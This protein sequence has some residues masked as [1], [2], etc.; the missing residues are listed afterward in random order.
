MSNILENNLE[1]EINIKR[2]EVLFTDWVK[3]TFKDI[4]K[5]DGSELNILHSTSNRWMQVKD[6]N[7]R[8]IDYPTIIIKR[9]PDIKP[10]EKLFLYKSF[11]NSY[12]LYRKI[13]KEQSNKVGSTVLDIALIKPPTYINIY[14]DVI[15]FDIFITNA[16][17]FQQLLLG[18][19]QKTVGSVKDK[20]LFFDIFYENSL[21][22]SNIL[23]QGVDNK[24]IIVGASFRLEGFFINKND[25]KIIQ[26][27]GRTRIDVKETSFK[28]Q[29]IDS[30]LGQIAVIETT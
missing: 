18:D 15:L 4:K 30:I 17:I 24:K 19:L 14:Y 20:L 28:G 9:K 13:N 26:S 6:Q 11:N 21:D 8:N 23:D 2:L 22:E 16:N 29:T 1:L 5:S 10:N 3:N 12:E 27:V 7:D 25:L